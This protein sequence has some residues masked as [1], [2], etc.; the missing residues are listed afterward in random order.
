MRAK[1]IE[2]PKG[3]ERFFGRVGTVKQRR[4]LSGSEITWLT[5]EFSKGEVETFV[6]SN[7]ERNELRMVG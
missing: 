6:W 5:L 1:V 4:W 7:D 3:K 2:K